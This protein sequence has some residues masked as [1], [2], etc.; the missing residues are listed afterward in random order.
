MNADDVHYLIRVSYRP[1]VLMYGLAGLIVFSI[2]IADPLQIWLLGLGVVLLLYPHLLYRLQLRLLA[3]HTRGPV[4]GC[5]DEAGADAISPDAIGSGV[6][7]TFADASATSIQTR[8]PLTD[9]GQIRTDANAAGISGSTKNGA[10]VRRALLADGLLTGI[11]IAAVGLHPLASLAFLVALTMAA[12]IFGGLASL[13]AATMVAVVTTVAAF[14]LLDVPTNAGSTLTDALS[15]IALLINTGAI[16]FLVSHE[17]RQWRMGHRRARQAS[18]RLAGLN[19]SLSKYV[20]PQLVDR[21]RASELTAMPRTTRRKLT[22]FFSDIEGFTEL[23]DN[24]EEEA[25]TRCLNQYL[26]RMAAIAR[27]HGGTLDKFLGDGVMVFFGD[28]HSRGA[29]EDAIACVEMALDMRRSLQDLRQVWRDE[30]VACELHIRIGISSGYCTVGSFG[31]SER[32]DYTVIGS[33]VN[34]ASRLEG[35]AGR[36]QILISEQT[37]QLVRLAFTCSPCGPVRVRGLRTPVAA[38]VV[39]GAGD[40]PLVMVRQIPG[41]SLS[42]EPGAVDVEQVRTILASGLSALGPPGETARVGAT[43]PTRDRP[44]ERVDVEINTVPDR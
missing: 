31:S 8:L 13:V 25:L 14:V 9:S 43:A 29:R 4:G 34:L 44:C 22:L 11:L 28:P 32:L 7:Q 41:F 30:G 38:Y 20:A 37:R 15:G 36:D 33:T 27:N 18:S 17:N 16:G 39:D 19:E 12:L 3:A 10:V 24:M 5:V 21:L 2:L 42:L 40:A 1:R 6:R 35:L 23:M 26:D